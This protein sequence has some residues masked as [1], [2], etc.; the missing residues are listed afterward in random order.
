MASEFSGYRWYRTKETTAIMNHQMD[1]SIWVT[2]NL[3]PFRTSFSHSD[4]NFFGRQ[5][6]IQTDKQTCEMPSIVIGKMPMMISSK[7]QPKL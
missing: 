5:T 6:P 2:P 1:L 4:G 3:E 7:L